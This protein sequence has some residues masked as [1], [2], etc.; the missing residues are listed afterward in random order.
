MVVVVVDCFVWDGWR[1]RV[2]RRSPFGGKVV[3][4]D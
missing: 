1:S 4:R 3:L 2:K